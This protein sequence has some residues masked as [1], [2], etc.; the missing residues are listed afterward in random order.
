MN[1][2]SLMVGRSDECVRQLRDLLHISETAND[3]QIINIIKE[4]NNIQVML[5]LRKSR[6]TKNEVEYAQFLIEEFDSGFSK[7]LKTG[8]TKRSYLSEKLICAPM[9]VSKKFPG[10]SIGKTNFSRT[11]KGPDGISLPSVVLERYELRHQAL[12]I[13]FLR[14]ILV[15]ELKIILDTK[16][17]MPKVIADS[18]LSTAG[19]ET[20]ANYTEMSPPAMMLPVQLFQGPISVQ[21]NS[22]TAQQVNATSLESHVPLTSTIKPVPCVAPPTMVV[23]LHVV[24]K[25]CAPSSTGHPLILQ[26]AGS[27][28]PAM[29][30][31][32]KPKS[33]LS[34]VQGSKFGNSRT[35]HN[36]IP[37]LLSGFDKHAASLMEQQEKYVS[38]SVPPNQTS[39]DNTARV[40]ASEHPLFVGPIGESP[41]ITSKSFDDLHQ[42]LANNQIPHLDLSIGHTVQQDEQ[43]MS[44]PVPPVACGVPIQVSTNNY[45]SAFTPYTNQHQ[46]NYTQP[47]HMVSFM[48]QIQTQ[49]AKQPI[50]AQQV[51]NVT[52]FP[53]VQSSG[54]ELAEVVPPRES[55][56]ALSIYNQN[57][58]HT[59]FSN[60]AVATTTLVGGGGTN[61]RSHVEPGLTFHSLLNDGTKR[62]KSSHPVSTTS[63]SSEPSSSDGGFDSELVLSS[64]ENSSASSKAHSKQGS[65]HSD[66]SETD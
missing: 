54:N 51:Q 30:Q 38:I 65:N 6:W 59:P 55:F 35:D 50:P 32:K 40:Q 15:A 62:F 49:L 2:S 56:G 44:V 22:T 25:P 53:M 12:R 36:D 8:H 26:R 5:K 41:Y 3:E 7:D 46:Q 58:T 66:S 31:D 14:K 52:S 19:K 11:S 37:D 17:Q 10:K 29:P 47:V 27:D 9:R 13:K 39:S 45:P 48:P 23:P 63:G 61:K 1:T 42:C 43:K 18:L 21:A 60:N 28:K 57:G 33:I 24:R 16:A 34:T 64:Y 4:S 20:Q